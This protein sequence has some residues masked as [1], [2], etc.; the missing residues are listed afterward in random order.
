MR[1][2][3][4]SHCCLYDLRTFNGYLL[5]DE[6]VKN[7][8]LFETRCSIGLSFKLFSEGTASRSLKFFSLDFLC[9]VSCIKTRN[10]SRM[11]RMIYNCSIIKS[12]RI[13]IPA[14]LRN[15]FFIY[16]LFQCHS[17]FILLRKNNLFR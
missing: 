10:V 4:V 7:N 5:C 12:C 16:P 1:T 2:Q 13:P 15:S 9:F 14:I 11:G 8:L 6:S 3:K 17:V